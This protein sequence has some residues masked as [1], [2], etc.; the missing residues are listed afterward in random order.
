M[1]HVNPIV[2]NSSI[3]FV[4]TSDNLFQMICFSD[5]RFLL[6]GQ[7]QRA[8]NK[9]TDRK[10]KKIIYFSMSLV[11]SWN[12]LRAYISSGG[13]GQLQICCIFTLKHRQTKNWTKLLKKA[14]DVMVWI[15]TWKKRAY[16]QI[17][18]LKK[19]CSCKWPPSREKNQQQPQPQQQQQTNQQ[20][21]IWLNVNTTY[22]NR[23]EQMD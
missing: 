22:I 6:G 10:E 8:I 3:L 23:F 20:P 14:C 19:V 12:S 15:S 18:Y 2:S 5:G 1:L 16:M 9:K 11:L 17:Y 21:I 7:Q 13:S 4:D